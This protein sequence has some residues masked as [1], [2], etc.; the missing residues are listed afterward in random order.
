MLHTYGQ[1]YLACGWISAKSRTNF[2]YNKNNKKN[3]VDGK[4]EIDCLIKGIINGFSS[5][6]FFFV[7]TTAIVV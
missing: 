3:V 4:I 5:F 2:A 7:V 6:F 1:D